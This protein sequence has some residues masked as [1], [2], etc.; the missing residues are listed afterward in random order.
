MLARLRIGVLFS[1]LV[2]MLLLGAGTKLVLD[3]VQDA[4]IANGSAMVERVSKVV[5]ATINR[6]FLQVDSVLAGLP[7]LLAQT[8]PAS[9]LTPDSASRLLRELTEQNFGFRDLLLVRPGGTASPTPGLI[10]WA[11]AL[12]ASRGRPLGLPMPEL[13]QGAAQRSVAIAGPMRNA[14]TGEWAL[15]FIRAIELPGEAPML[16]VAEVPVPLMASLLIPAV[17]TAGLALAL[18]R[19]DGQL[20]FS[21]PHDEARIG[22]LQPGL[23]PQPAAPGAVALRP[24]ASADVPILAATR[25]TLYQDILVTATLDLAATERPRSRERYRIIAIG[26]FAAVLLLALAFALDAALNQREKVEAERAHA[27]AILENALES[28]SDGFVMWDA[29]DRLLVTNQRYREIYALTGDAIHPGASFE[30]IIRAGIAKGQY[31]QAGADTEAFITD[32][33]AWHRGDHPSLERLLPDERWVLVTERRTPDGGTVGIRT[34]ITELKR[35]NRELAAANAA[36]AQA[37]EAKSRFLARMSH[38]LRTP[39]NGVLGLAQALARDPLLS[40]AHRAQAATLEMAGRHL[41]AV[42][43]DVLDLAQVEA[44]HLELRP[45]A[46]L[47]AELLA[48][49]ATMARPAA[50]EK[51]IALVSEFAD[52]LPVAVAADPTKLRQ[53]LLNLLANAVKFTPACGRVTLRAAPQPGPQAGPDIALRIEVR[54]TGPG[55]PIGAR[56]DIFGDFVQLERG[57]VLGGSGLGLAIARNIAEGMGGRIG[58]DQNAEAATGSLFWVELTLPVAEPP[59]PMLA[60]PVMASQQLRLLVADDVTANQAVAR[61][62]L[63]TAG[64]VVDCVGDGAL[65]VAAVAQAAASS[66]PYDAVLM[67]VM[68]P[69]V[70]GLEAS[71]RI[72]LLPGP[73]ARTP[74]LAV[75]ASAFAA[76]I[77]A[78][79]AAGM[80]GHLAKPIE[81]EAM[82]AVLVRLAAGG[83]GFDTATTDAPATAD[84]LAGLPLLTRRGGELTVLVPGLDPAAARQLVP[85]FIHEIALALGDLRGNSPS[86]SARAAHALAGAAATLGAQRLA[87]AARRLQVAA[88]AGQVERAATLYAETLAVAEATLDLLRDLVTGASSAVA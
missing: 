4:V 47:L 84:D 49:C 11:S 29:D 36:A 87:S 34:D 20:L 24:G 77:V 23:D 86:G 14:A 81:R 19:R 41:V 56:Q 73:E 30:E 2:V 57:G 82:L 5:E 7:S 60:T 17:D 51:S 15:Y 69:G 32:L 45:Q 83:S 44:G 33:I 76:D 52:S 12:P 46:L 72:R 63:E 64:H 13:G 85:E 88:Q 42:A 26:C 54:D 71:R 39:L 55:V 3:R 16:A 1:T 80:D 62:L 21:L 9:G 58:C 37:T 75:T 53:L 78:C 27:R 59:A 50:E 79:R 22:K 65:A 61:A 8:A 28:M 67:D 6:Q 74:I 18:E 40:A 43:N 25:T 10:P 48:G 35:A 70:D 31:P 38:E 66:T 68:M